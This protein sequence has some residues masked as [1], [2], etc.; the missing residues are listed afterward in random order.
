MEEGASRAEEA[1]A[2]SSSEDAS[3]GEVS[4]GEEAPVAIDISSKPLPA[5]VVPC[6]DCGR[7]ASE[8]DGAVCLCGLQLPLAA[9]APAPAPKA[10]RR[11]SGK[12]NKVQRW[13]MDVSR[14]L[15]GVPRFVIKDAHLIYRKA[16]KEMSRQGCTEQGLLLASLDLALLRHQLEQ[17]RHKLCEATSGRVDA[18]QLDLSARVVSRQQADAPLV[19]S[20][21]PCAHLAAQLCDELLKASKEGKAAPPRGITPAR[22]AL[23]TR[24]VIHTAERAISHGLNRDHEPLTLAAALT[25][26]NFERHTP[27]TAPSSK[28]VAEAAGLTEEQ[29][30]AAYFALLPHIEASPT[31]HSHRTHARARPAPAPPR[32]A[33][34]RPPRALAA[35]LPVAGA[36]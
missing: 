19:H 33:P 31:T 2:G 9:P 18:R 10:A 15:T 16:L 24:A 11:P 22:D 35:S 20:L 13:Y 30:M 3:E 29:L 17:P 25:L 32:P 1:S 7:R 26:F 27:K 36:A 4:S 14:R 23:W 34:P 5:A 8:A 21:A 6:P 28:Q 12:P